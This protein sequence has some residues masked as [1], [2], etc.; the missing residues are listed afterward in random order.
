MQAWSL[1]LCLDPVFCLP[2]VKSQTVLDEG[3]HCGAGPIFLKSFLAAEDIKK[4]H[5]P[6]VKNVRFVFASA[7]SL[8]LLAKQ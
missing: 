5:V 2:G 4:T 3:V 8:V 7:F 1:C 6:Q